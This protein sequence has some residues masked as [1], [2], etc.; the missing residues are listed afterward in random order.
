[1]EEHKELVYTEETVRERIELFPSMAETEEV[2]RKTELPPR[3]GHLFSGL[4][5]GIA[6]FAAAFLLCDGAYALRAR[7][8][9]WTAQ[10]GAE[11][12]RLSQLL[13]GSFVPERTE[14]TAADGTG[15]PSASDQSDAAAGERA[16]SDPAVTTE[17]SPSPGMTPEELYAYDQ[18]AV[19][20][21]M[22]PIVPMDLS[23]SA[24]GESFYYNDT[25]YSLSLGGL[26]SAGGTVPTVAGVGEVSVLI[27]HTHATEGYSGEGATY[28]DPATPLARADDPADGVIAVGEV[29]ADIL[30]RNGIV[31]LHSTVLHDKDSYKDS[32][33]RSAQTIQSYLAQYPSI[34]LVIDVHRDSIM[35]TGDN[36]VRPVTLVDGEAVA[37]V[38]CVVGSDAAGASYAD[39]QKNLALAVSLRKKLNDGY[40]N[41]CRPV[42]VKKSAY[43]QQYAPSSLLLEIGSSGNSLAEAQRAAALVAEEIVRMMNGDP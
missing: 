26:I 22:V 31:T 4:A 20:S 5:V 11:T 37:Q 24:Y 12:D 43:N 2:T 33:N 21:G 29:I 25:S 39:W 32:Y 36:L 16:P 38:M 14:S 42:Y 10:S 28:Y 8:Q 35:T 17:A 6:L 30:N 40:G 13:S 19:P 34:R 41:L 7:A 3:R 18:N 1:M 27:V 15:K 23:L 9:D